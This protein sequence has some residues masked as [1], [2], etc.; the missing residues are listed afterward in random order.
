MV[1]LKDFKPSTFP[2]LPHDGYKVSTTERIHLTIA[3]HKDDGGVINAVLILAVAWGT[4]LASYT[5]SDDVLFGLAQ[6]QSAVRPCPLR[7]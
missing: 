2:R 3:S 5:D 1:D 7:L 6:S 4:V